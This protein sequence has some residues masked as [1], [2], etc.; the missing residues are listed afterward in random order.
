MNLDIYDDH[1]LDVEEIAAKV[2]KRATKDVEDEHADEG[3]IKMSHSPTTPNY[4]W[5]NGECWGCCGRVV[6]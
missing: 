1:I 2:A 3:I 4:W 5:R 6:C